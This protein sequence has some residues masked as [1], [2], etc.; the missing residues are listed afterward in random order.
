[1]RSRD[2]IEDERALH[3]QMRHPEFIAD[4]QLE[5]LLDIRDLL[6]AMQGSVKGVNSQLEMLRYQ[7]ESR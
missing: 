6:G 2:Q 5:V 3:M 4:L 7:K 1:M